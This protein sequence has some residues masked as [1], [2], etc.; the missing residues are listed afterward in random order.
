MQALNEDGKI[1]KKNKLEALLLVRDPLSL[2]QQTNAAKTHKSS[3][4]HSISITKHKKQSSYNNGQ[5]NR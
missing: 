1:R 3:H 5:R 4:T 2:A